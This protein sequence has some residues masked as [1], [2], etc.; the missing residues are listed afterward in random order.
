MS[1][2]LI[3]EVVDP[4][5]G[6]IAMCGADFI[7]RQELRALA[8]PAGTLT[9]RP[10]PHAEIV[11][12]LIE[13]L[14]FRKLQVVRDR[15]AIAREG[16]RLFGVL[17]VNVEESG[18]RFA[19]GLRNSHDK[20]FSLAITCGYRVLVCDNL[21]F[22]GDF[23]PTVKKHSKNL[24]VHDVLSIAID[25]AHRS[26][27]PMKRQINV[28]QGHSLTDDQARVILYRIFVE[29][30]GI[31]LPRHLASIAHQAYFEPPHRE[32]TP[33]TLWSLSNS[34]TE[35]LKALEPIPQIQAAAQVGPFFARFS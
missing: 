12:A 33:R 32:F 10:V 15:Y 29:R 34:V 11:E 22:S 23:S 8:T 28:W 5:P 7:G 19:I 13:T 2:V 14:G 25:Q 31:E 21:C 30:D 17:E 1:T 24:N 35:S 18:V 26:F 3:P 4:P 6:L 9:H 16:N 20:S 27:E